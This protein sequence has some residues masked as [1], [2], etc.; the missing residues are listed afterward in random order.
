LFITLQNTAPAIR[1]RLFPKQL[2]FLA[3]ADLIYLSGGILVMVAPFVPKEW[4]SN[5]TWC[6]TSY[7]VLRFG[8]FV[9]L[10]HEMHIAVCFWM[11]S[12]RSPFLTVCVRVLPWLWVVAFVLTVISASLQPFSYD[13]DFQACAPNG[14]ENGADVVTIGVI[15]VCVVVCVVSYCHVLLRAFRR[16]TPG[17]V[18]FGVVK[19]T[20][21]Y[22]LNT[23]LCYTLLLLVYTRHQWFVN[24]DLRTLAFSLENFGGFLNT[25]TYAMQSRYGAA[26]LGDRGGLHSG[27]VEGNGEPRLSYRVDIGDV[28]VVEFTG[29][30]SSRSSEPAA[31]SLEVQD[32]F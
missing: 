30:T 3:L 23:L 1:N 13:T 28:H 2:R 32:G 29:S 17:S 27:C 12:F 22:I 18:I 9:S 16:Q 31:T 21:M 7:V 25:I 19:R 8:R 14:W 11:K 24:A 20:E 10:L 15:A 4:R 6:N 5:F 26:M